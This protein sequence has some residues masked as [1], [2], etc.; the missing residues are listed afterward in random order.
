ML[1]NSR[2]DGSV[3]S[4]KESRHGWSSASEDSVSL[5]LLVLFLQ[6]SIGMEMPWCSQKTLKSGSRGSS[7]SGS[8]KG[9]AGVVTVLFIS[10]CFP[11]GDI[12]YQSVLLL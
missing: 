4:S 3:I 7:S 12:I 2:S 9:D 1:N 5:S 8:G 6:F 10:A 11:D